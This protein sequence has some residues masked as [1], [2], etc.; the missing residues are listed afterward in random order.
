LTKSAPVRRGLALLALPGLLLAGCGNERQEALKVPRAAKPVGARTVSLPRVGVTFK[1]PANWTFDG[2]R[3]P[4][5]A[6]LAS[7][8]AAIAFWRYPRVERLPRTTAELRRSGRA[9]IAAARERDKSLKVT[10]ARVVRLGGVPGVQLVGSE[11]IGLVRRQVRSTHLYAHRA[12]LVID[13]YAPVGEFDEV[14]RAA[15]LPL[16]RSLRLTAPRRD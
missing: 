2:G 9:L 3:A 6:S 5:L 7:G 4:L 1:R 8:R 11:R 12:E 14:D 16:L 13:A 15:F 10:A